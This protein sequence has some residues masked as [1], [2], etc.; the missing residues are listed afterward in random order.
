MKKNLQ[1]NLRENLQKKSK[2]YKIK[3]KIRMS[4]NF[5]KLEKMDIKFA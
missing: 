5:L 4:G 1:L 2:N 3:N